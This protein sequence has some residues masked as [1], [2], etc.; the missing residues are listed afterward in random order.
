VALF[1]FIK[2]EDFATLIVSDSLFRKINKRQ[3]ANDKEPT[4]LLNYPFLSYFV[5]Y[6]CRKFGETFRFE[7][8]SKDLNFLPE[9]NNGVKDNESN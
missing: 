8:E 3:T 2:S 5:T 1:E 6:V 9:V 7:R 4:D